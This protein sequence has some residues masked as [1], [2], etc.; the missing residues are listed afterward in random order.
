MTTVNIEIDED[1][2]KLLVLAHLSKLTNTDLSEKDV[3]IEVKSTQNYKSE[4][5]TA[6][7]RARIVKTYAAE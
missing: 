5:E 1:T 2:I 4:W 3:K 7:F 6:K